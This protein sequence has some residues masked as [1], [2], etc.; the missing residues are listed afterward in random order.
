MANIKLG[1]SGTVED[2]H[3]GLQKLTKISGVGFGVIRCQ[4]IHLEE[5]WYPTERQ[6]ETHGCISDTVCVSTPK[7]THRVY[8]WQYK[9]P[10]LFLCPHRSMLT[11]HSLRKVV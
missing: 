11:R 7:A 1:I 3:T 5:K 2:G 4:A 6:N 10:G 9:V 8:K